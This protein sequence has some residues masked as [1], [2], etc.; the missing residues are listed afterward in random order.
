MHKQMNLYFTFLGLMA[1]LLMGCNPLGDTTEEIAETFCPGVLDSSVDDDCQG[2]STNDE[3]NN[4][5]WSFSDSSSYRFDSDILSVGSGVEF[6][7]GDNI[8]NQNSF[9]EGSH[10]QTSESSSKLTLNLS[11]ENS[12]HSS[13]WT[14]EWDNVIAYFPFDGDVVDQTGNLSSASSSGMTYSTQSQVGTHSG[15]F[16]GTSD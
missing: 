8:L 15:S 9:S 4:Y 11:S 6:A 10:S 3:E 12:N 1:V 13:S 2:L 16:D 7:N 5:T 14:P